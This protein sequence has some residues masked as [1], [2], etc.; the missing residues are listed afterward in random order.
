MIGP[1]LEITFIT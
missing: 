1:V